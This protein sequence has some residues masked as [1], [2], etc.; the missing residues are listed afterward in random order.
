MKHRSLL[1][2]ALLVAPLAIPSTATAAVRIEGGLIVPPV[3]VAPGPPPPL[4][5]E[6]VPPPPGPSG[7]AV[8]VPGHWEWSGRSYFW[9]GGHYVERPE[10]GLIWEPGRWIGRHGHWEW[11]GGHWRR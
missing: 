11:R 6:I 10:V 9:V 7:L 4:R 8:W 5:H 1:A 2:A 3:V